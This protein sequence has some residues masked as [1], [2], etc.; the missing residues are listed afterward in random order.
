VEV[1]EM[2]CPEAMR[3]S[4]ICGFTVVELVV[5]VAILGI[6]SALAVPAMGRWLSHQRLRTSA[7]S[8]DAAF[9]HARSEAVR[10]GNIQVVFFQTDAA[11]NPLADAQG[12][13]VPIL[14]L[15]DGR[16]GAA[17][18]NCTIDA[19]EITRPYSLETD[20]AFSATQAPAAV[21]SDAGAGDFASG[22]TFT[23]SGGLPASWIL[24]RP[25]GTPLAFDAGC[26]TGPVGSGGGAVYLSNGARDIAVVLTPLGGSRVH[27][28][29]AA[30][31]AW[32]N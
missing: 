22:I 12:N 14:V 16:P 6:L 20:V 21:P 11:G 13:A 31:A 2:K 32:S 3:Q 10:S 8:V 5:V 4:G 9:S 19:G 17:L 30:A 1:V 24:F 27:A 28:W 7:R 25:E 26:V 29:D 18:Q 15:D 23:D